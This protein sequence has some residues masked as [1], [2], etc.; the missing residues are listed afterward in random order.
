MPEIE[1]K[2]NPVDISGIINSILP[3]ITQFMTLY[4]MFM[5]L[6]MLMSIFKTMPLPGGG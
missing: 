4:L 2:G 5:L 3:L 6:N 1:A